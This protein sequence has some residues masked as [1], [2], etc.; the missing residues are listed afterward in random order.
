MRG[1]RGWIDASRWVRDLSAFA[2]ERRPPEGT[3]LPVEEGCQGEMF[4]G[5]GGAGL[6]GRLIAPGAAARFYE[7]G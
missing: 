7:C 1:V 6:R 3:E 5:L 2:E 4:G